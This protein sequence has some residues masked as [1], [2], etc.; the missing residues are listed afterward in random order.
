M[1]CP[2]RIVTQRIN[3]KIEGP[4]HHNFSDIE[5]DVEAMDADPSPELLDY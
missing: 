3:I 2:A 4:A 1:I 5:V